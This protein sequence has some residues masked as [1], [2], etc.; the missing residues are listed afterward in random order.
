MPSLVDFLYEKKEIASD[1]VSLC[2]AINGIG[3]LTLGGMNTEKHIPNSSPM[4]LKSGNWDNSFSPFLRDIRVGGLTIDVPIEELNK[5]GG[6]TIDTG[7]SYSALP[8]SWFK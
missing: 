6:V 2:W 7:A 8:A 4:L 1:I 3:L 5:G